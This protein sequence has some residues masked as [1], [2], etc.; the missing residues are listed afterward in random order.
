M[1]KGG[2]EHTVWVMD[3]A[4]YLQSAKGLISTWMKM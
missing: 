1:D 2:V 4:G 3:N